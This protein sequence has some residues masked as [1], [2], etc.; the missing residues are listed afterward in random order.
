MPD[1]AGYATAVTIRDHVFG[2]AFLVAYNAG[3][4]AH[5]V[6]QSFQQ[7]PAARGSVS[8]F[9]QCPQAILSASDP[10]HAVLRFTGWGTISVQAIIPGPL[11]T[12]NVQWQADVQITPS[13]SL[14]GAVALL[15]AKEADYVL[16]AWEFDVLSGGAFSVAAQAYLNGDTFKSFVLGWLGDAIGNISFPIIDF[17]F[18]GPFSGSAFT[19]V[20]VKA[21]SGALLLGFDMDNGV[22]STSGDPTQLKDLA[23]SNDVEVVV[24]P[25]AIQPL[26]PDAYQLV[27][28]EVSQYGAT[29]D[30]LFITCEEGQFRVKGRASM[31]E[32][33]A[34]FSLAAVPLMT[35]GIP[36][37]IIPLTTKKTMVIRSRTWPALSFTPADVSV[38]V[39]Q[40]AW[41]TL[42]EV[43]GGVITLGFAAF[44]TQAF[45]S[46]TEQNITGGILGANL[47]LKGVTPLVRRIG[48]PPTR[49]GI[50]QFEIHTLGVYIG[51]S[52][53]LEAPAANLSGVQSIP[54]DYVSQSIPYAVRLPFDALQDDPF[55]RVRWTVIDLDSGNTLLNDDEPAMNRLSFG[56]VPASVGPGLT[57]FAVV[58]RVYR[59][60]GPFMTEILN[61]TVR[62]TVGPALAKGVFVAWSYEVKV[63]QFTF[64]YAADQW[65]FVEFRTVKRRS[66]FHRVDKPCQNANHRSRFSPAEVF[67]DDLP[68]PVSAIL[69]NRTRLC[70][71][72]FF[73]GPA[74]TIA[75]L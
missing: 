69:T 8:F 43:I 63:P 73:G 48:T 55:L 32:G 20:A 51:I 1:Y 54:S 30:T 13:V 39:D 62:L 75:S 64:D 31:S 38:D 14:A 40:S 52:S 59:A 60:L 26:M 65:R 21:T 10:D 28:N 33:S 17:S 3:Q 29:L 11:E 15:S 70:D 16:A 57:R 74:S 47:N 5:T 49:F 56:F 9:F 61:Q 25:D 44:V 58:C 34:N 27:Q 66:V 42:V 24:N 2:D 4:I 18:L 19:N 67:L 23:G 71:Y 35:Y 68:F 7:L 41:V 22:F 53:Q 45:I 46:Q 12:R 37:A 6:S 72:C 50:E 36:G